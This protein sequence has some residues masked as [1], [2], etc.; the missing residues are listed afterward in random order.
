MISCLMIPLFLFEVFDSA[1]HSLCSGYLS[2][3]SHYITP[4]TENSRHEESNDLLTHILIKVLIHAGHMLGYGHS[5]FWSTGSSHRTRGRPSIWPTASITSYFH[6]GNR[7]AQRYYLMKCSQISAYTLD[8][9]I[10]TLSVCLSQGSVLREFLLTKLINAEISCYKADRF[11]RLEVSTS[12]LGGE[13]QYDQC[14]TS[15][16]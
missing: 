8:T 10:H 12:L 5:V 9:H 4:S 1:S 2:Q 6:R 13:Q 3:Y 11:S 15:T 7:A 14:T 16:T